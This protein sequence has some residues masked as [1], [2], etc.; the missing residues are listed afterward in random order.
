MDNEQY[1]V[2]ANGFD[3]STHQIQSVLCHYNNITH[4]FEPAQEIDTKGAHDWEYFTMD[5]EHYL[6]V[7]NQHDD[8]TYQIQSVLYLLNSVC[9]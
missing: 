6:V 1:L 9:W 8:S 5:N 2:V 3:G 7:A 4:N